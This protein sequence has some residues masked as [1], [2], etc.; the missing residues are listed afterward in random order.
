MAAVVIHYL[1]VHLD[2]AGDDEEAAFARMF[3][4]QIKRWDRAK[5][6]AVA[7][8]KLAECERR[9]MMPEGQGDES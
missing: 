8:R 3:E 4:R 9:L 5:C 2:V 6:E 7:R 1:E